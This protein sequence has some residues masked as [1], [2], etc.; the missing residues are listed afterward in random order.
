MIRVTQTIS[1]APVLELVNVT[2]AGVSVREA[3]GN[4]SNWTSELR[5]TAQLLFA[6]HCLKIAHRAFGVGTAVKGQW[7]T[8]KGVAP[9]DAVR[10][11]KAKTNCTRR[12]QKCEKMGRYSVQL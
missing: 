4:I 3:T 1:R 11:L 10:I 2:S 7:D 6:L 5:D 9:K 8:D 12:K